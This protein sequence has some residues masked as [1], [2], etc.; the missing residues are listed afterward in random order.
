LLDMVEDE[1]GQEVKARLKAREGELARL[2]TQHAELQQ[3]Q[4]LAAFELADGELEAV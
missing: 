4:K 2:Q 1:G 3:R